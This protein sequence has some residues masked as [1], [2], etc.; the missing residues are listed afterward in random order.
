LINLLPCRAH[1][2]LAAAVF[3]VGIAAFSG[4]A[5]AMTN[6]WTVSPP[7]WVAVMTV[8]GVEQCSGAVVAD[9][10]ALFAAHCVKGVSV[11]SIRVSVGRTSVTSGDGATYALA[12]APITNPNY[13]GVQDDVALVH[14]SGFD[15][16]R[17]HAL[18][19]ALDQQEVDGSVGVT[20]F[21]YGNTGW[22]SKGKQTGAGQLYKSPDSAFVRDTASDGAGLIDFKGISTTRLLSGD[23]GA[24]IVRWLNGSWHLIAVWC[25]TKSFSQ[26]QSGNPYAGTSVFGASGSSR[27]SDWIRAT[28]G[29][30]TEPV[31]SI[32]QSSQGSWMLLADG[33]RH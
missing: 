16:G 14:L 27:V 10:W 2:L 3:A 33:Y 4:G 5:Q 28:A 13:N 17:W 19:L 21:G 25:C 12:Q 8:S 20:V 32:L 7:P 24:P 18:P 9:G 11:K 1:T 26:T 30:P 23:S 29:I 15:S 22:T 31:S 6:G